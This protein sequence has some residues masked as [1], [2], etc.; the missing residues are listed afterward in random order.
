VTKTEWRVWASV[1][2]LAVAVG[3]GQWEAMALLAAWGVMLD[4]VSSYNQADR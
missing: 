2:I 3:S 4:A 1:G